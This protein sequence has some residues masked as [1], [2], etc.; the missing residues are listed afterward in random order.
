[1]IFE[2][3]ATDPV[4]PSVTP[5]VPGTDTPATEPATPET[6]ADVPETPAAE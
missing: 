6:P 3:T 4:D 1:M 2:M 5:D